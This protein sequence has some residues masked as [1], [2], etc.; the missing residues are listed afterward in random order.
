MEQ[1]QIENEE[2]TEI[3]NPL[4]DVIYNRIG[5]VFKFDFPKKNI[6]IRLDKIS[7]DRYTSADVRVEYLRP[8][9]FQAHHIFQSKANI[10]QSSGANGKTSMVKTCYNRADDL[11]YEEWDSIIEYSCVS[12]LEAFREDETAPAINCVI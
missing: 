2:I 5:N 4:E 9:Q 1:E 6:R 12:V 11:N 8:L 3:E 7:Q 10:D